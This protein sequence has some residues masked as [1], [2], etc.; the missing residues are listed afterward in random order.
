MVLPAFYSTP[1]LKRD[2]PYRQPHA[3]GQPTSFTVSPDPNRFIK[4]RDCTYS[5][6]SEV[7]SI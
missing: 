5:Q 4:V 7:K 3:S 6:L 2:N 1:F